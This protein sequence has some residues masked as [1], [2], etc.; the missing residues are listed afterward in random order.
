MS[1]PTPPPILDWAPP[2]VPTERTITRRRRR[3]YN[4]P[5]IVGTTL[6][7]G[8][9]FIGLIVF[10]FS[11][12]SSTTRLPGRKVVETFEGYGRVKT[13]AFTVRRDWEFVF[14][15]RGR[16]PDYIRRWDVRRDK[17]VGF[18]EPNGRS[19]YSAHVGN[20][21]TFRFD[22]YGNDGPWKIRIYQHSGKVDW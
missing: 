20:G 13:P 2:T 21:G 8:V 11:G 9:L 6:T 5:V 16:G 17:M 4:V 15:C 18:S 22:S 1:E 7:A 10:A 12:P 14:E 3:T 19:H